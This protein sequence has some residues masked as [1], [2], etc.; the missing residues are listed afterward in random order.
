MIAVCIIQNSDIYDDVRGPKY[1]A[2]QA[3][4]S[5]P[6]RD[7]LPRDPRRH[8]TRGIRGEFLNDVADEDIAGSIPPDPWR[9]H[10]TQTTPRRADIYASIIA[11]L[12]ENI[13]WFP[14]Y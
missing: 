10:W 11:D 12:R 13:A 7:A 5:D 9:L 14:R 6:L 4:F 2:L 3:Y 1:A 8:H